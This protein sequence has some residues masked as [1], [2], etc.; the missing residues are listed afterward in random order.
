MHYF[1]FLRLSG[2]YA[3]ALEQA[4]SRL[5][6]KPLVVHRNKRVI[7]VNRIAQ[8]RQ[9]YL[10]MLL[11]EAKAILQ[12][13]SFIA[14]EEEPFRDAQMQWLDVC[15]DY[16]DVIEPDEQ[17][18][19]WVDLSLH[20]DPASLSQQIVLRIRDVTG[21]QVI[22]GSGSSKWIA[23]LAS[24]VS[25]AKAQSRQRDTAVKAIDFLATL[26]TRFLTPVDP[27]HRRSCYHPFEHPSISVRGCRD[28]HHDVCSGRIFRTGR[29]ALSSEF[30]LRAGA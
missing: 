22:H 13:A 30:D 24:R 2:F 16:S 12:E 20:P 8:R 9:I 19:A 29:G 18:S 23:A 11:A 6:A 17:H 26:K 7:D 25:H 27:E 5:S 3:K 4:D 15:T 21:L 10:G 14:W 1:L 28:P